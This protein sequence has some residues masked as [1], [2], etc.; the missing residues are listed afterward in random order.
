[1][2]AYVKYH[3]KP[4]SKYLNVSD[5]NK[6]FKTNI[7]VSKTFE[8]SFFDKHKKLQKMFPGEYIVG[9]F[10]IEDTGV[11]VPAS[12]NLEDEM[13]L[14]SEIEEIV[15]ERA[16]DQ[17]QGE[18]DLKHVIYF[19]NNTNVRDR[20]MKGTKQHLKKLQN[21]LEGEDGTVRL[22]YRRKNKEVKISELNPNLE[23]L[24]AYL[25]DRSIREVTCV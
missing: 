12:T 16:K 21:Y 8:N 24:R 10:N 5:F 14:H 1:M 6:K 7:N 17:K 22:S 20:L 3:R 19:N 15:L 13:N 9:K 4:Y 23:S 11:A 18:K 2:D 25:N